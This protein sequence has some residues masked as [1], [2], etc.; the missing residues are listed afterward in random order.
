MRGDSLIEGHETFT[1][2]LSD[3]S[4]DI[5]FAGNTAIGTIGA[6][7]AAIDL[8]V[9]DS[10][11]GLPVAELPNFYTGSVAA[12]EKKFILLTPANLNI[13]ASGTDGLTAHG[14]RN[15]LDGGTGSNFLT[16]AAGEDT[17]FLDTRGATTDIWSTVVGFG[18]G[19]SATVWGVTQ[20]GF[21]IQWLNDLGTPG[22]TG[23]TMFA[24]SP[25]KPNALL[26][27]AG[28]SNAD[29]ASRKVEVTFGSIDL[30]T[31]Y[32]FISRLT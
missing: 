3:A 16:G 13:T 30:A 7:D 1:V 25:G 14:G 24:T 22:F 15:V 28:F 21:T 11:T 26:T 32:L 10:T 17:F 18:Q 4:V 20:E 6:D 31:P 2:S 9:V 5:T 19:D 27:L 8:A 29:L 12:V 23:L